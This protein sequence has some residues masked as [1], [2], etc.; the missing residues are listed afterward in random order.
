MVMQAARRWIPELNLGPTVA[1][2]KIAVT[3]V[4]STLAVADV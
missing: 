2:L 3:A 4:Y 1:P